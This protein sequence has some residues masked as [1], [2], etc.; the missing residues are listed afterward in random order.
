MDGGSG[1]TIYCLQ[2]NSK[3]QV[4]IYLS[5]LL[6][7]YLFL[8]LFFYPYLS[9]YPYLYI[10]PYISIY[11]YLSIFLSNIYT[12]FYPSIYPSI[13]LSIYISIFLSIYTYIPLYSI[14]KK[15]LSIFV[16]RYNKPYVLQ[17]PSYSKV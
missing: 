7:N 12:S 6:S 14:Y 10:N 5:I 11:P 13:Y 16:C 2:R 17:F 9:I 8:N 4:D 15:Y 1:S 3:C